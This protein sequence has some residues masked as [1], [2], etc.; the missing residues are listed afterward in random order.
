MFDLD[1]RDVDTL[2]R[3]AAACA[4]EHTTSADGGAYD[5]ALRSLAAPDR[6]HRLAA[7]VWESIAHRDAQ[8]A[9]SA[10][11][12]QQA[13]VPPPSTPA[14]G[15]TGANVLNGR[16]HRCPACTRKDAGIAATE[17]PF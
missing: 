2:V 17:A 4:R 7:S 10:A 6:A 1:Q 13:P 5:R 8:A 15:G 14:G 9:S 11:P 16:T 12:T 3:L